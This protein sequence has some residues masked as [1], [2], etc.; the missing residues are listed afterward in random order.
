MA[1]SPATSVRAAVS[2]VSPDTT[3][4]RSPSFSGLGSELGDGHGPQ[5][6]GGPQRHRGH[7]P[8]LR[9]EHQG[10]LDHAVATAPVRLGN[11]EPEQ[12]GPGQLGPQLAVDPVL[13]G[14]DLL[15]PLRA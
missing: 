7:R 6:R 13:A 2:T 8:S 12:V 11:R 10:Q 4:G 15:D 5:H 14:L 9:L 3:P 1:M